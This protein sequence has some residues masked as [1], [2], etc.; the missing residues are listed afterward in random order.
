MYRR[1]SIISRQ[2]EELGLTHEKN[3][4]MMLRRLANSDNTAPLRTLLSILEPVKEYRRYQ[5]RPQTMLSPLTGLVDAARP[6]SEAFRQFASK[7]DGFISDAPRF[8]LHRESI[9]DTLVQ[10]RA[11][12]VALG[13]IIDRAPA[14]Q[15]VRPLA[16]NLSDISQA[17]LEAMTYLSAGDAATT[18][19]RDAQLAKLD[20][21]AKPKAALEFVV[22]GNVRKLVIAAAELPQLKSSTPAEWRQ[23][24]MRL[25]NP[26]IK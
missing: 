10:W 7:V 25:A 19:W 3:Y 11:A 2:L 6:D 23:R 8:A 9:N 14:L 26:T 24:V 1:L 18:E 4:P 15:E 13:P 20:E 22:V 21:A 16:N 5:M 17:G 12:G